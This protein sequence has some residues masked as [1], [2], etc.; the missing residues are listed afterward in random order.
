MFNS[1]L[2]LV[3]TQKANRDINGNIKAHEED[4]KV[5]ENE[6]RIKNLEST[7]VHY[8]NEFENRRRQHSLEIQKM[9]QENEKLK[10]QNAEYLI[11][12]E[13]LKNKNQVSKQKNMKLEQ[14]ISN[15]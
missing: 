14:H 15:D 4:R 2:D 5:Q 1:I 13:K 11:I 7:I 3:I 8:Q 12:I 6:S 9:A 10:N